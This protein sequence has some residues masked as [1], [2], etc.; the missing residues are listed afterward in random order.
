MV[1]T[2]ARTQLAGRGIQRVPLWTAILVSFVVIL[3]FAHASSAFAAKTIVNSL[4]QAASGEGGAQF[5]DAT[6]VA[7][8]ETGAGG[9]PAG[10]IYV[11]D[12]SNYRIQQFGPAGEF[13]R[14]WGFGV[15]D[16]DFEF[17]ICTVAS[18]CRSGIPGQEPGAFNENG[19]TGLAVDQATGL[20]YIAD[21][22]NHRINIFTA[23]GL[24]VGAF[25]W[26]VREFFAEALQF[27]TTA[28]GCIQGWPFEQGKGGK[29]GGAIGGLA[30]SP[31]GDIYVANAGYQRVD[32][33]H[34]VLTDGTVSDVEFVE[35]F[36]KN[37][38]LEGTEN[39][40]ICTVAE[41]CDAGIP[42]EE[43]G[44]FQ[45][46]SPTDIEVDSE[47]NIYALDAGNH[48][49]QKFDS[50]ATPI[51]ATFGGAAIT[52]TFEAGALWNLGIDTSVS[53][54]PLL[55]SGSR[56]AEGN[57]LAVLELSGAGAAIAVNGEDFPVTSSRGL[58]AAPRSLGGN[59]YVSTNDPVPGG[60]QKIFILNEPPTVDPVTTFSG[61]TATFTG[62][63][64][65]NE[66]PVGYHFEYST[67][68]VNWTSVP[69]ADVE[70]GAAPGT[71]AVSQEVSGLTGS[72]Q[73]FVRL[74]QFR[75]AGG[76]ATSE[77]VSFTT[78]P[79]APVITGAG[80]SN[81]TDASATLN[82]ELNAQNATTTYHFEYGTED[83]GATACTALASHQSS[84]GGLVPVQ[85]SLTGLQPRTVYHFRLVATNGSG[86]TFGPDQ[87]FE[88]TAPGTTLPDGRR[89]ELVS[90][91]DANGLRLG[92]LIGAQ[93]VFERPLV[94]PDGNSAMFFSEGTIPGMDGNGTTD[95]Y[96]AVR[97]SG[98]WNT[99]IISPDGGQAQA[100]V[101]GGSSSDFSASFWSTALGGGS[102]EIPGV[103]TNVI[104]EP[105]GIF[106]LIGSGS[107]A[108]DPRAR[109]RWITPGAT[110]VIFS[111][112]AG[113]AVKIEPNA[114]ESGTG[115]IYD[116][117]GGE[118][119]VVSLLPGP[120]E[121]LTPA[122][123][124][125]ANYIGVSED[126]TAVAFEIEGT[127]YVRLDNAE[128]QEVATGSPTY[129][130]IAEGG[131]RIFYLSGGNLFAYDTSTETSQ[132]I[133]SGGETTP[134]NI[135]A[136]GS[137]AYFSSPQELAAGATAGARNLFVWD[138]SSI[139]FV[140]TLSQQ[141]FETFGNTFGFVSLN[142]WTLA[143]GPD[144]SSFG[145]R[146]N[147]PTRTNPSG[148]A[149]VFQSHGVA[150]FP[151]DSNGTFQVYRYDDTDGSLVCL[152]CS[153]LEKPP[154]S[155]AE[156]QEINGLT[157]FPA[158]TSAVSRVYNVT[159]DGSTVFFETSDALVPD[160]TDGLQDVYQWRDGRVALISS[161][162]S[163][164]DDFLFAVTPNGSDVL[165][166]TNDTLLARDIDQ[167]SDSIYDARVNGGFSEQSGSAPCT[168]E[169]CQGV[170]G[171]APV[172][173][174]AGSTGLHGPGN[175]KPKKKHKKCKPAKSKNGKKHK[176]CKSKKK[177]KQKTQAGK[178]SAVQAAAGR[179]GGAK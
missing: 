38:I 147:S 131:S 63:V 3:L 138:G 35:T 46:G 120:G 102:L 109:G 32:V 150:E 42:T 107:V 144:K 167:G 161:G 50:S 31:A 14:T 49:I 140:A 54:N 96:K 163:K 26:N 155:N 41:E 101:A 47:G 79:A 66:V 60:G 29:F 172:F 173:P 55:V 148:S 174:A 114:P 89:Y 40:E 18:K 68:G 135:S 57:R 117:T 99:E 53:P 15:K 160:D 170:P 139:T 51:D 44:G 136:D 171:M 122:D 59:V 156:L 27:C 13:V 45:F 94:S 37:V 25:G 67:D 166:K 110:H 130:G 72:Q 176:K 133:G 92:D 33:F 76:R 2:V 164:Q 151:F 98:G 129:A 119:H 61:T 124:Q 71:I 90:P 149:L 39:Y 22:T 9:V 17:Q 145:G 20:V 85:D 134:V 142:N 10:S 86:T 24:F 88:T 84:S 165:F 95:S 153:P 1:G 30:V 168:G 73:Y 70:A 97:G 11:G 83:C 21:E 93:S 154:T 34:P 115:A 111:T 65:S 58:A 158:P 64:V 143:V 48:R 175:V 56:E 62:E 132:P 128:T 125:N 74:V 121:G 81:V 7:V 177:Q 82:A 12:R 52:A 157:Q 108:E 104:R 91:P 69:A 75:E 80:A 106:T 28:S 141:D 19:I 179:D 16:G 105:D 100:P 159:D 77:Q 162:R 116:R 8:N 146:A 118:T 87:S 113:E 5:R 137:H 169:S 112:S 152:S 123:G 36:G 127:L 43:A 4:G 103:E 78:E 178:R 23:K 126:G 6:G